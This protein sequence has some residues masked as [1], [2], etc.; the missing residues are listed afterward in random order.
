MP[1]NQHDFLVLSWDDFVEAVAVLSS[2]LIQ[3]DRSVI[4][5]V[6]RGGL[7]LAVALSHRLQLP[8][9]QE[10]TDPSAT[11]WVDDII[12]SGKTIAESPVGVLAVA[13]MAR[14]TNRGAVVATIVPDERWV[15]FPWE[16]K[17]RASS[18]QATY[19]RN[20]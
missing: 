3:T 20:I 13:W 19:Q 10:I 4:Y 7:P 6:P 1:C 16:V 2:S 17:E 18:D 14:H 12:D 8:I 9:V 11:I 5:G 15:L